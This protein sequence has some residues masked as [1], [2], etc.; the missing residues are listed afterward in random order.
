MLNFNKIRQL[1]ADLSH[2][3]KRTDGRRYS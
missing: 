2:A 3:D 1:G